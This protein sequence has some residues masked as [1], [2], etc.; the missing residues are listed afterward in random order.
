MDSLDLEMNETEWSACLFCGAERVVISYP[1]PRKPRF[2][3]WELHFSSP[4]AQGQRGALGVLRSF[5]T[6]KTLGQSVPSEGCCLIPTVAELAER[7][8]PGPL[9]DLGATLEYLRWRGET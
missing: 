5:Q 3:G 1:C 2:R 7:W 8:C 9:R 4:L 6:L